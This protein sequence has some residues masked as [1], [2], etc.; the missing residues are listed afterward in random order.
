MKKW[1]ISLSTIVLLFS[2]SKP[3]EIKVQKKEDLIQ[4]KKELNKIPVGSL[5]T[6]PEVLSLYIDYHFSIGTGYAIVSFFNAGDSATFDVELKIN[7]ASYSSQS[8]AVNGN[9]AITVTFNL[10]LITTGKLTTVVKK[11]TKSFSTSC[12]IYNATTSPSNPTY[13]GSAIS[14]EPALSIYKYKNPTSG[15]VFCTPQ[16]KWT[17]WINNIPNNETIYAAIKYVYNSSPT[18]ACYPDIYYGQNS[19]RINQINFQDA[20]NQNNFCKLPE[21]VDYVWDRKP[22]T[23]DTVSVSRWKRIP[24]SFMYP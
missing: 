9:S 3:S 2:C 4:A 18:P 1:F 7:D 6:D 11:G 23:G 19:V 13:K 24:I 16:L 20:N 5:L 22:F 12:S 8:V 14:V 10:W 17:S 21:Y 15:I